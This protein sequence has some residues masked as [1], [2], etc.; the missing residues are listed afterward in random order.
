MKRYSA[1]QMVEKGIFRKIAHSGPAAATLL[2]GLV[3]ANGSLWLFGHG[4]VVAA[5]AIWFV[6]WLIMWTSLPMVGHA[7]EP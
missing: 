2:L 3:A 7:L 6:S 4:N 5:A 1:Q